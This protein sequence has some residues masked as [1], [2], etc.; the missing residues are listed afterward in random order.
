MEQ[1]NSR[2]V[3]RVRHELRLREV[4]VAGVAPVGAHMVAITFQG[5]ALHDFV[6]LSFDDHVKFM[7]DGADGVQ[8][9]RDYT[10][11]RFS[12]A[13]RALTL[14]FA[15]H[16]DGA[17][18]NWARQARVGQKVIVG[19]PR[20]SMIVPMAFD[21]Y[22]LAGDSTALPAMRRRLEELPAGSRV[23][24]VAAADAGDRLPFAGAAQPE[25]H[26]VEDDD[27]LVERVRTL[28]L[29]EG[30][31]FAWGAGE[32]AAMRRLRAVLAEE[33]GIAKDAMRVSAY[34]KQGVA[35]HHENLE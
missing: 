13:A 11:R 7:F 1:Q 31:G 33:K 27:A 35:D 10:P 29:P 12:A 9:R 18:S 20:G 17:A 2:Q 26:W 19:G 23:I 24:V 25:V 8:V 34:W 3:Q 32:A 6:S 21:W 14:E 22:L 15:L 30:A 28:A 5:E 16:G 4:T